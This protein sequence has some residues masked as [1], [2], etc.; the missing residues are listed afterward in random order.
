MMS[1]IESVFLIYFVAM[2]A[3]YG[4]LIF[5]SVIDIVQRRATRMLE[6]DAL[7]LSD[8]SAPPITVIA[9][10][11]NE[12]A[13]IVGSA[14]SFLQL[15]YTNL[16]III[17]NDG[18]GDHTL[19]RLKE[20]FELRPVDMVVRQDVSTKP[21]RAVYQSLSEPRLLVVDKENGGKAD[22]L[23]AGLN[24][25]RTPLI[26]C[27]DAD[28]LIDRRAL[29]RMVEPFVQEDS[30]VVAVGGTVRIANGCT[31]RDGLVQKVEL[32]KS[33]LARFQIVEYLRAF[34]FGRMGLN[35]MGGNL[36][37]SGAF[38]LF[39][40][41]AVVKAGGYHAETVGEDMELV[42]RIHRIM[43]ESASEYKIV[44][45]PDPVCYTEAP[46]TFKILKRQRDR[47]QRG[48]G[49]ALWM[50]MR[51]MLNPAFGKTGMLVFP[52]F[53]FFEFLG[54]VVELSG[55]TWF[56]FTLIFGEIDPLFALMFFAVAFLWGFLLSAQSI[57]LDGLMVNFFHGFRLKARLLWMAFAENFGYR[58]I[59]L[60]YRLI[61]ILRFI[62]GVKTWGD[63]KR[64]G[65]SP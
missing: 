12:E 4:W 1:F 24:V 20:R 47:W 54:P 2:N 36:I 65:F 48:L 10:A 55:Y 23:N 52:I 53:F 28:T 51:M 45:I 42:V 35:R 22:A 17:V 25:C 37:I 59:T 33:L 62:R 31:I 6:M 61:G 8:K 21:V 40:R 44:F 7:F 60:Y 14:R 11:H 27:A 34:L 50:H 46:E 13:T 30:N 29:L 5:L 26:C 63:M 32:P 18:S 57:L 19:E 49:D 56:I 3:A 58:Q 39:L 64:K 41:D 43:R 16:Q 38:G 15:E 9:P